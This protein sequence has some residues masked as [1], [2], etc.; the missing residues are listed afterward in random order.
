MLKAKKPG[1]STPGKAKILLFGKSGAGKTW[2]SL[3]FPG[4]YYIDSEGGADLTHYQNKLKESG[5]VYMSVADGASDFPTV[6]DEIK[7]L[8]T[9]SHNYKTVAI[10]SISKL[11][12][13]AIAN[14]QERLE[15]IRQTDDFG[16]SK[17]P[18]I[19]YM[20]KLINWIHRLDMNVVFEAHEIS[21]WG[22]VKGERKE[23]GQTPDVWDKLVYEL[24]LTLRIYKAPGISPIR[25]CRI[26]KSRLTG[27]PEGQEFE[28]TYPNFAERF[29]ADYIQREVVPIVLATQ[30]QI[31][32]I[33]RLLEILK[34][35]DEKINKFL[36]KSKV[37]EFK[38][39]NSEQADQVINDL[40]KILEK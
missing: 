25:Y 6:I 16:K 32:E 1:E 17:K 20:R 23:I 37:S 29:G 28:C 36:T 35:D 26:K 15:R 24:H 4:V 2:L 19:A 8:A 3:D 18:A 31:A 11:W 9:E 33:N 39:L 14:E 10:G 30:K 38:D 21:E 27:F 5:G 13:T 34:I 12:H 22:M 40:T 7:A